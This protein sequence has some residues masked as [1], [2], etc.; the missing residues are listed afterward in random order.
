MFYMEL[1]SSFVAAYRE[2]LDRMVDS[3]DDLV[4]VDRFT[5]PLDVD[6]DSPTLLEWCDLG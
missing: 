4:V 6:S 2:Y 1:G 5:V 3:S